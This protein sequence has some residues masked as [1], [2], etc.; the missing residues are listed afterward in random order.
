MSITS[1]VIVGFLGAFFIMVSIKWPESKIFFV[2]GAI[3]LF[4]YGV[5]T[6]LTK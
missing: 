5:I 6:P 2:P 4:Y 3:W 1:K